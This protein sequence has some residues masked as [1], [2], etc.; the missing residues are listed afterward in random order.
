MPINVCYVID[1]LAVAGTELFL[2]ELISR[3]NRDKV[4]PHLCLLDG[5]SK[6]SRALEPS[7]CPVIRLGVRALARPQTLA[8]VFRFRTFLRQNR[9]QVVHTFFVDSTYFACA[10]AVVSGVPV[11]IRTQRNAGYWATTLHRQLLR[12][13]DR[14][15][16]LTTTNCEAGRRS[17]LEA[18]PGAKVEVIPN[19]ID[20][21]RFECSRLPAGQ[22]AVRKVGIVANLRPVKN[23][24]LFI[25]AAKLLEESHLNVV[26][27][28][29]GE[30]ELNEDL[31]QLACDLGLAG[32]IQFLGKLSDV[33]PFL[34]GLD[35][36]VLCSD[37][38]GISNA[39]L[40]YMSAA[41]PIVA[42]AVGGTSELIAHERTGLLVPPGDAVALADA[43][44]RLLGDKQLSNELADAAYDLV[45]RNYSR[46]T[47]VQRYES[48]Y[49]RLVDTRSKG[50]STAHTSASSG[51]V[52]IDA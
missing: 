14:G 7:D 4:S 51:A 28:I 11:T 26:F 18:S 48:L 47:E 44:K 38:E 42:T 52:V 5:E 12:I 15:I 2:L 20:V 21:G 1:N 9:I 23:V 37:S 30:G 13:V 45:K 22:F 31:R 27:Q 16:T 6:A 34:S 35:V 50:E 43:I 3:L 49:D 36:A 41:R 39:I 46:D 40:E 24:A 32:R 29:A 8:K 33:R 25:Q 19:G 17:I 10:T